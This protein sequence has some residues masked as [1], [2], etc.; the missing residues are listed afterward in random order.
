MAAVDTT[1]E[2]TA[3]RQCGTAVLRSK[4]GRGV[5]WARITCMRMLVDAGHKPDAANTLTQHHINWLIPFAAR[6]NALA[7][8]FNAARLAQ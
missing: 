3:L 6:A 1:L 5:R 4:D 8:T 2:R 7:A